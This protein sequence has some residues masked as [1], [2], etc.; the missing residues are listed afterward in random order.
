ME[1]F[2]NDFQNKNQNDLRSYEEK[3]VIQRIST[4]KLYS[5][6]NIFSMM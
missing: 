6:L 2:Q 3:S 4:K 1:M 5:D